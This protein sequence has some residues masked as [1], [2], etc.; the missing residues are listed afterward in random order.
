MR[1]VLTLCIYGEWWN[2]L[3]HLQLHF[4]N[5]YRASKQLKFKK[6]SRT[7]WQ[8]FSKPNLYKKDLHRAGISINSQRQEIMKNN[9][10]LANAITFNKI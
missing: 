6:E 4:K 7:I 10:C 5:R 2:S 3:L 8:L 1:R 9:S